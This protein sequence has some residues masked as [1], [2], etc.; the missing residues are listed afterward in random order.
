VHE[1]GHCTCQDDET[2]HTPPTSHFLDFFGGFFGGRLRGGGCHGGVG[3]R[4][5]DTNS[6]SKHNEVRKFTT[7]DHHLE[8]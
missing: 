3:V 1:R 6:W 8:S 2:P 4:R 7:S 5:P